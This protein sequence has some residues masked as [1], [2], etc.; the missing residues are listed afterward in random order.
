MIFTGLFSMAILAIPFN[1]LPL[2]KALLREMGGEGAFY[3]L[4]L[5]LCLGFLAVCLGYRPRLPR[6]L[7]AYLL[8]FFLFWLLLSGFVNLP[9]ILTAKAKGRWAG[10]KFAFQMLVL[11]FSMF[12]SLLSYNLYR[13]KL[14]NL[15]LLRRCLFIGF[16]IVGT[17][18][19][20]ELF[21]FIGTSWAVAI[22]SKIEPLL[23]AFE[24]GEISYS[25]GRLRSVSAEPSMLGACLGLML[26]WIF[27]YM[28][29][30][31]RRYWLYLPVVISLLILTFLTF[32]RTAYIISFF[33][34]LFF[35]AIV[36]M[37]GGARDRKRTII[38]TTTFMVLAVCLFS[39]ALLKFDLNKGLEVVSSLIGSERTSFDES[40]QIRLESQKIALK[41]AQEHPVFGV[42][43]GQYGFW[44]GNYPT[45]GIMNTYKF[46][47]FISQ[48]PRSPWPVA[49]NTYG[50]FAAE[51]GMPGLALWLIFI[52]FMLVSIW[53]KISRNY[54]E[55]EQIDWLGVS[56]LVSLAGLSLSFFN[57]DSIK[58]MGFWMLTGLSWGYW[59]EPP[60]SVGPIPP[61]Q[62]PPLAQE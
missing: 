14:V 6:N 42:G 29:T 40:T 39:Y 38:I 50:R 49:Y 19:V 43:M 31:G 53:Q 11:L 33:E 57:T 23:H 7:A 55:T 37:I 58:F 10:E 27:S 25:F 45:S 3:F 47:V 35:I 16:L 9:T 44:M 5:A 60:L 28:Y 46:R 24:E 62:A 22:R 18:S 54:R 13:E 30:S 36:F 17:Y 61:P 20:V 4:V 34:V 52:T 51:A 1:D 8:V 26:P 32:S 41:I 12:V 2:F 59:E 56:L 48:D 15:A 21:S